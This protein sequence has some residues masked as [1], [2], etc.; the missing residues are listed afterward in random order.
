VT[1][2]AA[3]RFGILS[4]LC[5]AMWSRSTSGGYGAGPTSPLASRPAAIISNTATGSSYPAQVVKSTA[6]AVPGM[7]PAQSI[8]ASPVSVTAQPVRRQVTHSACPS[9]PPCA[10]RAYV[11][12][13]PTRAITATSSLIATPA[14]GK[15]KYLPSSPGSTLTTGSLIAAPVARPRVA[16][17]AAKAV[18]SRPE[19]KSPQIALSPPRQLAK[20]ASPQRGQEGQPADN[21]QLNDTKDDARLQSL[22]ALQKTCGLKDVP[23]GEALPSF[24][25]S[26]A[27]GRLTREQFVACHRKLLT[28]RGLA[29]PSDDVCNAV[30]D[31]VDRDKNHVVDLMEIV[32]GM[33]LLCSGTQEEK[34]EAVFAIFD[35]NGDGYISMDEMF[36]FLTS[37]FNVVLTPDVLNT[38]NSMGVRVESAEDLA[39]VTAMECF[40]TADLNH[41]Q[42]LSIGE[43]QNWFYS[44]KHDP[45]FLFSP[46]KGLLQ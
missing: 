7:R 8:T 27:E 2:Y 24:K 14:P 25:F 28:D 1:D 23:V 32:C 44:P 21:D 4:P 15:T 5:G 36:T 19:A 30:F 20:A 10:H 9:S 34:F 45:A 6:Q 39:A 46:M 18:D 11:S 33:S 37:V 35:E 17:V 22:K 12:T 16:R 31:L 29:V 43:F 13:S 3:G 42:K 26:A 40:K 41:D 38:M